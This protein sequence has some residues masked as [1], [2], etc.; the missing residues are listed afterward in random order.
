[1][2]QHSAPQ[3]RSPFTTKP[4]KMVWAATRRTGLDFHDIDGRFPEAQSTSCGRSTASVTSICFSLA[5]ALGAGMNPCPR[6]WPLGLPASV[7]ESP[8]VSSPLVADPE[9]VRSCAAGCGLAA[10][11]GDIYCAGDRD[12]VADRRDASRE[13]EHPAEPADADGWEGTH[14]LGAAWGGAPGRCGAECVCGVTVDGFD[15]VEVAV[16]RLQDHIA[17]AN[18]TADPL[19]AGLRKLADFYAAY[20]D[21]P[22]PSS[23]SFGHC[24]LD[25]EGG[26][27]AIGQLAVLFD[28]PVR[29]TAVSELQPSQVHHEIRA[30]L[31]GLEFAAYWIERLPCDICGS[32]DGCDCAALAAAEI[33]AVPGPDV[34]LPA[35]SSGR[36]AGCG[37][38]LNGAQIWCADCAEA[39]AR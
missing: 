36:C 38:Q 4:D 9:P 25:G 35:E 7:T 32:V 28:A 30:R 26:K 19:V 16:Y 24:V 15:T 10:E 6:C 18:E 34:V 1:M 13:D 23:P 12:A 21:A 20:P 27:A 14:F 5:D 3:D 39:G 2:Q 33:A 29:H 11:P 17:A 22:R 8:A 31:A 37:F